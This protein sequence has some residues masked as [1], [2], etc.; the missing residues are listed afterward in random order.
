MV[1]F[2]RVL[3]LLLGL[4]WAVGASAT[5]ETLKE[6]PRVESR[7]ANLEALWLT[8]PFRLRA[9]SLQGE[10]IPPF[11]LPVESNEPFV[12]EKEIYRWQKARPDPKGLA[13]ME[14][15]FSAHRF[16]KGF[17]FVPVAVQETWTVYAWKGLRLEAAEDRVLALSANGPLRAWLDG[18]ALNLTDLPR[19]GM[20]PWPQKGPFFYMQRI[21]LE[22]GLHNLLLESQK[23]AHGETWMLGAHWLQPE[24][25]ANRPLPYP[26]WSLDALPRRFSQVAG[27]A[28]RKAR[29][30]SPE[31][32]D[33]LGLESARYTMEVR[34]LQENKTLFRAARPVGGDFSLDILLGNAY[35]E[36]E[37][38]AWL[39]QAELKES[40]REQLAE[41]IL[42]PDHP[43][44]TRLYLGKL[45]MGGKMLVEMA[46]FQPEKD[47]APF[48]KKDK[49]LWNRDLEELQPDAAF[50]DQQQLHVLHQSLQFWEGQKGSTFTLPQGWARLATSADNSLDDLIGYCVRF[51]HD[52]ENLEGPIPLLNIVGAHWQSGL[53]L[54]HSFPNLEAAADEAGWA[55]LMVD[56]LP[57]NLPWNSPKTPPHSLETRCGLA[58]HDLLKRFDYYPS[59][60]AFMACCR[61]PMEPI[62]TV[63]DEGD[64][65]QGLALIE[66]GPVLPEAWSLLARRQ[67]RLNSLFVANRPG[68]GAD[69]FSQ[70]QP[71]LF[72]GT[73]MEHLILNQ[74]TQPGMFARMFALFEKRQDIKGPREIRIHTPSLVFAHAPWAHVRHMMERGK[75]VQLEAKV[76]PGE[77]QIKIQT[78]NVSGFDLD[79]NR[80]PD[81]DG[82]QPIA[83]LINERRQHILGPAFPR[84]VSLTLMFREEELSWRIEAPSENTESE[85]PEEA[86]LAKVI[87]YIPAWSS[88]DRG[89][90]DQVLARSIRYLLETDVGLA[91]LVYLRHGY[92][93]SPLKDE[94]LPN[95]YAGAELAVLSLSSEALEAYLEWNF[96]GPRNLMTDGLECKLYPPGND[97]SPLFTDGKLDSARTLEVGGWKRE[98]EKMAQWL[99]LHRPDLVRKEG[100]LGPIIVTEYSQYE[101][102]RLF[103]EGE[104]LVYEY[105]PDWQSPYRHSRKR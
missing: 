59:A 56:P 89:G 104:L 16:Q 25:F 14:D 63:L 21:R 96:T 5:T 103:F 81:L 57:G 18:K 51:P 84:S 53:A 20:A 33:F 92:G 46:A 73:S 78:E 42:Q 1:F 87:E 11:S 28:A 98:L 64:R 102:L 88:Y 58:R 86:N 27:Q 94:D 48:W 43:A 19:E 29:W 9:D 50:E 85:E 6:Y 61:P 82:S 93:E 41:K 95:W 52:A 97:R 54:A 10:P 49:I 31:I 68:A 30:G 101:A 15:N 13:R 26:R 100:S 70:W 44:A 22:P 67:N 3:F 4:G 8:G 32:Q 2:R 65:Y 91:P 71:F 40:Q 80:I 99:R 38:G 55:L 24:D 39:I 47:L 7:G 90:M 66:C 37:G 23:P 76:I 45:P 34:S 36:G 83:L 69:L 72:L 105:Y 79:L 62:V 74:K 60:V 35:L 75:P 12:F 17:S 77:N